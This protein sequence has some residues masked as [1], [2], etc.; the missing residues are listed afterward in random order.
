[1][2]KVT[3]SDTSCLILFYKIGELDLLKDLFGKIHITET[4]SKE[5][6]QSLPDWVEVKKPTSG[7]DKGLASYLD[8]GEATS[9]ALASEESNSLLIIDEIKGRKAATEMGVTITGSL[10]VL[11]TAKR[12]GH[13]QAVKPLI[14]KMLQTNFWISQEL[15]DRVL[16]IVDET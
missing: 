13:I 15:V 9:I 8:P 10:G 6:S 3:V 7:L 14:K 4:V 12:K 1:M 5:F 11:V 2:P 16:Q